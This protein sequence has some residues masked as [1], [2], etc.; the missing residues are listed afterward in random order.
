M[1]KN[2]PNL[3]LDFV[4]QTAV[5][6]SID[7]TLEPPISLY[8]SRKAARAQLCIMTLQRGYDNF[9]IQGLRNN[10]HSCIC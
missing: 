10:E 2:N 8:I 6:D 5:A 4:A 1:S 3:R 9:E 7:I